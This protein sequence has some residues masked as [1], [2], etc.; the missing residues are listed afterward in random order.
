LDTV[1]YEWGDDTVHWKTKTSSEYTSSFPPNKGLNIYIGGDSPLEDFF[2]F[3]IDVTYHYQATSAPTHSPTVSPTTI[4]PTTYNPTTNSPTMT[5]IIPTIFSPKTSRLT[6]MAPTTMAPTTYNPT[7]SNP[8]SITTSTTP[9]FFQTDSPMITTLNPTQNPTENPTSMTTTFFS[10]E[11]PIISTLNPT[12][13]PTENLTENPTQNPTQN[14]IIS[15]TFF[16][17]NSPIITT[18][19]PTQNPIISEMETDPPLIITPNPTIAT[20][21]QSV[22]STQNTEFGEV[23]NEDSLLS[24]VG[25]KELTLICCAKNKITFFFL[26][27]LCIKLYIL[28]Y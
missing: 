23:E 20:T 16:Q 24:K 22:G 8:T 11:S 19:N 26:I 10:T 1:T 15:P 5:T 13:N 17:T 7:T 2:I 27:L 4:A 18:P 6:T 12:Q 28:N 21:V 14:P 9:T 25:G 3:S